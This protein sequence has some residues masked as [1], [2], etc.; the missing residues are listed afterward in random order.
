MVHVDLYC[1]SLGTHLMQIYS[2]FYLLH[3]QGEIQLNCKTGISITDARPN[4]QFLFARI[5][6]QQTPE[7]VITCIF[8]MQDSPKPGL[9]QALEQV[10]V[11]IKRSLEP[12][13]YDGIPH[14]LQQKFIP[15]GFN[16]QVLGYS[17]TFFLKLLLLEYLSRPFIPW[18]KKNNFHISNLKDIATVLFLRK[19]NGLLS[20]H[21]LSPRNN[22][23]RTQTILFQC[24]LWDVAGVSKANQEDTH[25]VNQGRIQLLRRLKAEFGSLFLGG[26]Q[27]NFYAREHAPDLISSLP[28]GR[29]AYLELVNNASIVISTTG[30]LKSN[31]WKLGEYIALGKCI[32]SEPIHTQLPGSFAVG[33]NYREFSNE[34]SCVTEIQHLL[35]NPDLI[36]AMEAANSDYYRHYLAP[37]AM[38]KNHITTLLGR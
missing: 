17:S 29:R 28:S 24:R 16:Y 21:E 34:E 15:F 14:H 8:D 19:S 33:K 18:A 27:N 23:K 35:A 9:P 22:I 1:D 30:L 2:G 5:Y 20:E 3:L 10:D 4:R 13:T 37:A 32:V 11:Y 25:R 38:M 31:G 12:E 7:K 6:L 36:T 26:L